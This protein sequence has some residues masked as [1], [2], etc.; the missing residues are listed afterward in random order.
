MTP[1]T[2][3]EK[4]EKNQKTRKL[5]GKRVLDSCAPFGDVLTFCDDNV[6]LIQYH[7]ISPK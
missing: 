4:L 5:N 1:D 3:P 6:K 7:T 2:G